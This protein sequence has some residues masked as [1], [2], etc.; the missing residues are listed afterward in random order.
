MSD[1]FLISFAAYFR[2]GRA[3]EMSSRLSS[4]DLLPVSEW[5]KLKRSET[6]SKSVLE[7]LDDISTALPSLKYAAKLIRKISLFPALRRDTAEIIAEIRQFSNDPGNFASE[8]DEGRIGRFLFLCAE[9]CDSLNLDGEL[10]LHRSVTDLKRRL[11]AAGKQ[12][13]NDGK[14]IESLTFAELGVYLSHVEGE[15]E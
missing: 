2:D 15:I 5:E 4:T 9:L 6:G 3:V 12:A 14:S 13:A 11:Q 7:S 1:I 10:I 8:P